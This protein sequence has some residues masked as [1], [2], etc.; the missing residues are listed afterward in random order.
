M[1]KYAIFGFPVGFVAVFV[2]VFISTAVVSIQ[3]P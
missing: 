3:P 1:E 2:S